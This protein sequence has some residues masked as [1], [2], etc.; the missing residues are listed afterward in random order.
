MARNAIP[1]VLQVPIAVQATSKNRFA[2]RNMY[3]SS[4]C[5]QQCARASRHASDRHCCGSMR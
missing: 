2:Q 1:T 5:V 3:N 4:I